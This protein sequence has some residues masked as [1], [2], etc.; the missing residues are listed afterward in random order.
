MGLQYAEIADAALLTQEKLIK[1]G[2]FLD[3]QT[4]LSDHVAVREMWKTRQHQFDGGDPWRFDIQ[5]DHNHSTRAVGLYETDGSAMTDTMIRGVIYC[6]HVNSHYVYDLREPAFQ[7]G[8]AKI[9]DFIKTK[10]VAMMVSHFEKME[11]WLWSEPEDDGKTIFGIGYWVTRSATEGFYGPNPTNFPAGK[12]GISQSN[13]ARHA[14]WSGNY[15]AVSKEDLIR[16]MRRMA[17]ET[18]FRSPVSH[19]QPTLSNMKNGIYV[20][21]DTLG[22]IEEE[23]E[24]QNMNLGN[25]V[26]S[27][28]G[29]AVF[30]STPFT[31]APYLNSDTKD[32]V[33]MLDWKWL[34]IGVLAGWENN[35]EKPYR[36]PGKHLV[37]RVDLDC[38]LNMACTNL[39][40]QGVLCKA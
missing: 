10:Y 14:N 26:A 33:Y 35:L 30:R 9:V 21:S 6:R 18:N 27:K 5:Y 4:D 28:D 34:A 40:Q 31:Y 2:A 24:K 38:S 17:R 20:N 7:R 13:Y 1:R 22:L 11:E 23:L 39:R 29:R 25:N 19:S 36:V 12:A 16:K 3:M 8:G 37:R 15:V 32:P